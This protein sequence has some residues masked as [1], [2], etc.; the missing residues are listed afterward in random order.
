[1]GKWSGMKPLS[2]NR[3]L[4]ASQRAKRLNTPTTSLMLA[5]RST[6][7]FDVNSLN[8][9]RVWKQHVYMYD[10]QQLLA[11]YTYP[12]SSRGCGL[13]RNSNPSVVDRGRWSSFHCIYYFIFCT[14]FLTS[15]TSLSCKF[16]A[17]METNVF[18][19][20]RSLTSCCCYWLGS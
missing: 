16:A 14:F 19:V 3:Y 6:R 4:A 5:A 18:D 2:T 20:K 1:M 15:T 9:G 8:D 17:C 13:I 11:W 12:V 7:V 10:T